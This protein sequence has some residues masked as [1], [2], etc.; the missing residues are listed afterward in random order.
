ME[1][2]LREIYPWLIS[3][4]SI[5]IGIPLLAGV[6]LITKRNSLLFKLILLYISYV[7][8][9]E[10][11]GELTI[12]LG[13]SNNLWIN[14]L[15]TPIEFILIAT[16]YYVSFKQKPLKYGVV[17]A[18]VGFGAFCILGLFWGEDVTQMNSTPRIVAAVLLIAMAV[19]Y[20]YQTANEVNYTY[21]DRDPMFLLSSGIIIYQAGTSMAYSMFNAALAESYD[22][23]RMCITVILVLN[24]LF[25][26]TLMLAIRRTP[27]A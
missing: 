3:L 12:Y 10:V 24:I 9:S 19:L 6:L 14:H 2:Y 20:F 1:F 7:A 15:D 26:I 23:A 11:V 16:T 18:A 17:A 22:S 27:L 21:L 8:L 4:S 13:T 25:R 5:S